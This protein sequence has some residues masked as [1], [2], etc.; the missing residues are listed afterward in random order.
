MS[1]RVVDYV[2]SPEIEGIVVCDNSW[3]LLEVPKTFHEEMLKQIKE[4]IKPNKRPHISIAKNEAPSA[5]VDDWGIKFVGEKIK[6]K[7][8]TRIWSENGYHVWIN[9][10]SEGLCRLRE[11][12]GLVTLKVVDP[13]PET[14]FVNFHFTLGRLVANKPRQL[15][16]QYR[17]CPQSHIDVET[18]MQHL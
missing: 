15:R 16:P 1:S 3:Y 5:N 7:Y 11:H 8:D 10:Y 17:L 18:L 12:F 13:P 4:P 6:F 14:F 2:N 9:C